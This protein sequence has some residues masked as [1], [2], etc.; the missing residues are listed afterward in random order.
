MQAAPARRPR[1]QLPIVPQGADEVAGAAGDVGGPEVVRLGCALEVQP[2]LDDAPGGL[3][4][5]LEVDVGVAEVE[6]EDGPHDL[7]LGAGEGGW[8][9]GHGALFDAEQELARVHECSIAVTGGG[10][11][12]GVTI[13][14]PLADQTNHGASSNSWRNFWIRVGG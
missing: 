3:G 11:T 14:N 4:L 2:E 7:P 8:Q 13:A 1:L 10:A 6:L 5:E 12:A 9:G